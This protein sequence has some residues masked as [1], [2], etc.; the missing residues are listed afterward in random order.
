MTNDELL[1]N[2]AGCIGF[3]EYGS[4]TSLLSSVIEQ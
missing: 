4:D 3:G 2:I 1:Q